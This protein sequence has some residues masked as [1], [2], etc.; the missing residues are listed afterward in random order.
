MKSIKVKLWAGMMLLVVSMLILLWLFQIVFLEKFYVNQQIHTLE[1][2]SSEIVQQLDSL[3]SLSSIQ[4]ETKITEKLASFVYTYNLTVEIVD[5]SGQVLFQL[6]NNA[7]QQ[8]GGNLY[9]KSANQ[10]YPSVLQGETIQTTF[11]H[12]R[13]GNTILMMG[14]P[15]QQKDSE[16][17]NGALIVHAPLAPVSDTVGILKHQLVYITIILFVIAFGISWVIARRFSRPIMKMNQAAKDIA[18]GQWDIDVDTAGSDEISQLAVTIKEMAGDLKKTDLLRK[19]LIG[20]IS[21]ELRTPL[22]LIRG[23]AETVRDVSWNHQEKREKHLNVIIHES[24]RLARLIDDILNLSQLEVGVVKFEPTCIDLK[25]LLIGIQNQ[26]QNLAKVRKIEWNLHVKES[27]LVLA[28][29]VRMEQVLVNLVGNAFSHTSDNGKIEIQLAEEGQRVKIEIRDNGEGIPAEEL[30]FIWD[31][32]YK[33][34]KES[35]DKQPGSGLGLAIVKSIL[36][37]HGADFGVESTVGKG[38]TFWFTLEKC[39]VK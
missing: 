23:Y 35:R 4:N 3:P 14:L 38:T 8:T 30:P 29:Q 33:V 7:E 13:F 21:H 32:Y 25:D 31:R 26:F 34:N 24:D 39:V 10:I 15:I 6:T 12:P 17:I 11:E 16:Q 22:S 19:E 2:H 9:T 28:D 27:I 36:T 18:K 20:N 1:D 5:D 37:T